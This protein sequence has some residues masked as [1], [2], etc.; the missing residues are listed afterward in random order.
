MTK[1]QKFGI[2]MLTFALSLFCVAGL[3]RPLSTNADE[4]E[5]AKTMTAVVRLSAGSS[6]MPIGQMEDGAQVKV[7]GKQRDYYKIDCYDMVG[8]ISQSQVVLGEDGKYYVN[9]KAKSSETRMLQYTD[10]GKALEMRHNLVALAKK[11]LGAR[12][13]SGGTRP[14]GFDCSGFTLY[15]FKKQGVSLHRTAA[16][17]LRDGIVIPKESLQVGDL[18][19][20]YEPGRTYPASHV[21]VYVGNN[22]MA[23]AGSG[24][25]KI[26]DLS[27]GYYQ[28]YFLC[29][30]RIIHTQAA[31]L[32]TS[33]PVVNA[34]GIS[35]TG[36]ISGRTVN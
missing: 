16:Q 12:Y 11:N 9:C 31:Q 25:T 21:G 35:T 5:T 8:Y 14:G 36:G 3:V 34:R 22:R 23:H 13:V 10:Y 7:L 24:G 18:L 4:D 28:D 19:F 20:F 17:Q 1:P 6:A 2:R 26:V 27:Q 33:A 15:L 30:R 29:A 32:Q